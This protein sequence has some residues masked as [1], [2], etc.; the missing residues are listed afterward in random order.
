MKTADFKNKSTEELS[1]LLN[2]FKAKILKLRFDLAD[3]KLKNFSDIKKTKRSIARVF[4]ELK[5]KK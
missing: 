1:Q 4:T 5:L 3:K 2:E